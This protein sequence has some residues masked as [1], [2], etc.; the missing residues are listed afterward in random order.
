MNKIYY[1][2]KCGCSYSEDQV[3]PAVAWSISA[4][5]WLKSVN[6]GIKINRNMRYCPEHGQ[7]ISMRVRECVECGARIE[8]HAQHG[9]VSYR[10][11]DCAYKRLLEQRRKNNLE[12]Y[13][14]VGRYRYKS[15]GTGKNKRVRQLIPKRRWDCERYERCLFSTNDPAMCV[16]CDRYVKADFITDVVRTTRQDHNP[17]IYFL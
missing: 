8:N 13:Y 15:S 7:R 4:R 16:G 2:F 11:E 3:R 1:V 9:I 5:Q 6:P 14:L 12:R 17:E 10:C